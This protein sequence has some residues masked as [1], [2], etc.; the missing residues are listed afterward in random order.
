MIRRI[1][2]RICLF[3]TIL[4]IYIKK[5]MFCVYIHISSEI[6]QFRKT[7]HTNI[8]IKQ[9]TVAFS[10]QNP[11]GWLRNVPILISVY[12]TQCTVYMLHNAVYNKVCISQWTHWL[13][14]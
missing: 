14:L 9:N 2:P 8:H 10:M 3:E 13:V 12:S 7:A 11:V 4:C 6:L 5:K 1:S